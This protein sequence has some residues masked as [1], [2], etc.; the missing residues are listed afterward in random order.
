MDRTND[1]EFGATESDGVYCTERV[2]Q[3]ESRTQNR[4]TIRVVL[5]AQGESSTPEVNETS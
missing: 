3:I 5:H 2:Q 1:L 4:N